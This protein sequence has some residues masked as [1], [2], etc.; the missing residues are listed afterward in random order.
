ML[1]RPAR[2]DERSAALQMLLSHLD[3]PERDARRFGVLD[4]LADGSID[5]TG[6]IVLPGLD[7]PLGAVLA[8]PAVGG[9]GVVWPPAVATLHQAD[10]VAAA[11]VEAAWS[12]LRGKGARLVQS[13]VGAEPE[14]R[15][16]F[17]SDNGFRRVTV[18]INL[19]YELAPVGQASL[20]ASAARLALGPYD[21]AR[22]E[23]FH[24]TLT[25]TYEGSLDCPEVT[26]IRTVEEVIAGHKVQGRYDPANWWLAREGGEPVGL[27][28]QVDHPSQEEREVAYL[29]IVPEARRK[30]HARE[31]L[32]RAI[33]AARADGFSRLVLAVDERNAPAWRLY[34]D[35]G[36][37]ETGRQQVFLRLPS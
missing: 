16:R 20:P 22:P 30:G 3:S 34:S 36:F 37:V 11:L 32:A 15:C 27:L 24:R 21:E 26:G 12:W 18:L 13:L 8:A 5:P 29:G 35:L 17:L 10:E 7:R 23:A 33:E 6:L 19:A 14:R 1:P 31:L 9:G 4:G 2:P 28:L 25:R